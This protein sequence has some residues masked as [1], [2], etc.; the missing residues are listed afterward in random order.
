[1]LR[2][3]IRALSTTAEQWPEAEE[4]ALH[5]S[6]VRMAVVG[7]YRHYY[8]ILFTF[9]VETVHV[10]HVRHAAQDSLTEDDF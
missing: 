7:K 6:N 10:Y 4:T 2:K 5:G 9:D 1:M 8:R 3:A